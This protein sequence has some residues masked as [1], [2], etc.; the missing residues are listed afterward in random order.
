MA[1][2]KVTRK[3]RIYIALL[4]YPMY[5]KRMD[6][7]TTS[8]TNLDIHD[9]SRVARTYNVEKFFIVHPNESQHQIVRKVID[10]WQHGFGGVYNPD[11]KEALDIIEL[12]FSLEEVIETIRGYTGLPVI[13]VATDARTYSNPVSFKWLR[14]KIFQ[15]EG[16]YLILFGTG[17]GIE[18]ETLLNCSYVLEPVK[19]VVEYN[20]LS[21]RSA[22]SIILDRLLGDFWFI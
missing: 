14:H 20:H 3:A 7:I 2:M 4:H 10:Y 5:N 17:Y 12:S 1:G 18:K 22:I 16:V 15:E 19:P 11:R 8:V 13:T 9:I 6:I 21:V